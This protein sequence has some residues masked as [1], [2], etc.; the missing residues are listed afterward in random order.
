[1]GCSDKTT[2][3]R[4]REHSFGGRNMLTRALTAIGFLTLGILHLG[5]GT[6]VF[7]L[8]WRQLNGIFR[9]DWFLA[10]MG[11]LLVVESFVFLIRFSLHAALALAAWKLKKGNAL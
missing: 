7:E 5:G 11:V 4:D 6:V 8:A 9:Y 2:N 10:F 3:S 1:M